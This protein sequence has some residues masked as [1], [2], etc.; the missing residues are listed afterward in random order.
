MTCNHCGGTIGPDITNRPMCYG[1]GPVAMIPA[2][3]LTDAERQRR[4]WEES[5]GSVLQ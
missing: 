1:C 3:V 2:G 5:R 4:A